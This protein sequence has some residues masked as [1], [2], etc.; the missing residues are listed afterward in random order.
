M[1]VDTWRRYW[2][3]LDGVQEVLYFC[4]LAMQ[5]CMIYPW[6]ALVHAVIGRE[7]LPFWS[8]CVVMW[9]AYL[10]SS[11]IQRTGWMPDRKQALVTALILLSALLLVRVHVYGGLDAS[12]A[13]RPPWDVEW[14]A[15]MVDRLFGIAGEEGAAP[16]F[17]PDLIVL[18][19]TLVAWWRGIVAARREYDLHQVWF[20]F[21]LGIVVLLTYLIVT[22]IG[23]RMDVTLL[24]FGYFFFGLMSVALA[25]ILEL[26]GIQRS[27]MG[28]RQWVALL[29][30]AILGNLTLALLASLL[31]S[32]QAVRALLDRVR[33]L[34]RLIQLAVWYVLAAILYLAWPLIEWAVAWIA[35]MRPEGMTFDMSPLQ[36]P[37]INP[38][39]MM[40][41]PEAT[42]A[43]PWCKTIVVVVAVVGAL[44]LVTSAIR[45]FVERQAEGRDV[46]RESLWSS[47]ELAQDLKNSLLGGLDR[48]RTLVSPS[49]SRKRRSAA[50]IRKIYASMVDLATE[51]GYPRRPAE[52]PYEY[53]RTLY[54]AFA[55]G[56]GAVD[57]IT[58]AYV[59][60]HYGSVPDNRAE[61]EHIVDCWQQVQALA[62]AKD[63]TLGGG[64]G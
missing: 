18:A 37:L 26:G 1:T 14:I 23:H 47:Q 36:S 25:R 41:Q 35:E 62:A 22:L 48:L 19:V 45:R 13:R 57:T 43:V 42:R 3:S 58:E 30:G 12:G 6:Q 33:P 17:V 9:I 10:A 60:V 40:Q 20:L 52:T 32:P 34:V 61:M 51:A 63:G 64:R 21:R 56:H 59:R 16:G 2:A 55:G 53:R 15:D 38:L 29:A 39:E 7:A 8:V 11:V 50:S 54:R 44:F 24:L 27:S 5:A 46:E 49:G 31:V 4:V 28:R